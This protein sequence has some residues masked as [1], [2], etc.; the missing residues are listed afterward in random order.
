MTGKPWLG[1]YDKHVPHTLAP[2]P[3]VTLVDI[4]AGTAKD[5]PE[6]TAFFFKGAELN[7]ALLERHSNAFAAALLARG[8][9]KGDRVALMIP[10]SPQMIIAEFAVWKAGGIVVPLNPLYSKHELTY[11]LHECSASIAVVLTPFYRK[12]KEVQPGTS[13]RM[14]VAATIKDYLPLLNRLCFTLFREKKGGHGV[15]LESGDLMFA[16]MVRDHEGEE[17]KCA[18][19]QPED[20]ALF[21][22]SGGTGGLPKWGQFRKV[23]KRSFS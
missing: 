5:F 2:Y 11:V 21:L 16:R 13:L 8:L 1:H 18:A 7:Y 10:N 14:V 22:F 20:P 4:I 19:P 23:C 9:K 15:S 12:L 3:S 6:K 17:R